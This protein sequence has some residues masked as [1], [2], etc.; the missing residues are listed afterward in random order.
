MHSQW[1]ST[2]PV[3]LVDDDNRLASKLER[4][5]QHEARL[6][7]RSIERIDHEQDA[8][9]HAHDALDLATEVGVAGGVD[10][11]DLGP[12][13]A[14]RRVLR[15]DGDAAFP[16]ERVGVHDALFDDLVLAKRARLT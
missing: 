1:I 10:D 2:L 4:L 15:E 12:V 8:I 14:D 11:V 9:D 6:R 16:L 13:P 7:H 3:D 5:A